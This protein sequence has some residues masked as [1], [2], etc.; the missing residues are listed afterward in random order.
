VRQRSGAVARE[1]ARADRSPRHHQDP[2]LRQQAL[3]HVFVH[4]DG[5][6][7]GPW[8]D[9]GDVRQLQQALHGSVL[10][11]GSVQNREHHVVVAEQGARRGHRTAVVWVDRHFQRAPHRFQAERARIARGTQQSLFGFRPPAA[12]L[13]DA[14]QHGLEAIAIERNEDVAR[15]QQRHFVFCRS[16]AKRMMTR[17]LFTA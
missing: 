4:A 1:F 17:V 5:R 2:G 14:D 8:P 3:G 13:V 9:V 11:V 16:A 10:A 6:A 15:R 12:L 7:E